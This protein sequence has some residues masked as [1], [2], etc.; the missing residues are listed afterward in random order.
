MR[1]LCWVVGSFILVGWVTARIIHPGKADL[2]HNFFLIKYAIDIFMINVAIL[3]IFIPYLM[4]KGIITSDYH[5]D[6]K[7]EQ[8]K[9]KFFILTITLP[10]IL[11]LFFSLFI[12]DYFNNLIIILF[13]IFVYV[14]LESIFFLKKN[15]I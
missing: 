6:D 7:H 8:A 12:V 15:R 14:Y 1:L 10:G 2:P 3:M 9:F 11:L 4:E 5:N 13:I